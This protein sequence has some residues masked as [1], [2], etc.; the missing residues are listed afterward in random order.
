V[1]VI[2]FAIA[3]L[4]L[5][6]PKQDLGKWEFVV[7]PREGDYLGI[8]LNDE[9]RVVQVE[10]LIHSP[11]IS[12]AIAGE[13]IAVPSVLILVSLVEVGEAGNFHG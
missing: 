7:L 6:E 5:K 4:Q 1:V 2:H 9:P 11:V 10:N 8:R 13:K 12:P 3:T